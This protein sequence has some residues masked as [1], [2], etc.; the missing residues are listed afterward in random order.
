MLYVLYSTQTCKQ[1]W[2]QKVLY[3]SEGYTC[4][5]T[6]IACAITGR[7]CIWENVGSFWR[8]PSYRQIRGRNPIWNSVSWPDSER[9][10][11]LV[12]KAGMMY[13]SKDKE[14]VGWKIFNHDQALKSVQKGEWR[15]GGDPSRKE[16]KRRCPLY[17]NNAYKVQKPS[18]TDKLVRTQDTVSV[19]LL[20]FK[21]CFNGS[22][23]NN[24]WCESF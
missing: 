17:S 5:L 20:V 21:M 4:H 19:L 12:Q 1:N 8:K 14:F 3:T 6:W 11:K 23:S 7:C 15:I 9:I 2:K 16:H 24:W 13:F 22:F 10:S 18:G